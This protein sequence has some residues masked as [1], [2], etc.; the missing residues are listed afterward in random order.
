MPESCQ[1]GEAALARNEASDPQSIAAIRA[2][3]D[4]RGK[5]A[6]QRNFSEAVERTLIWEIGALGG[7]LR[8]DLP[9]AAAPAL[10]GRAR[11]DRGGDRHSDLERPLERALLR[12]ISRSKV[13]SSRR[14][15]GRGV[16]NSPLDHDR[17]VAGSD[18]RH[19]FISVRVLGRI[20][21][22]ERLKTSALRR[23]FHAVVER[24]NEAEITDRGWPPAS[25][26]AGEEDLDATGLAGGHDESR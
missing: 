6:N 14:K 13:Q 1:R 23:D 16:S 24:A 19:P 5:E 11:T 17:M 26:L 25:R 21:A 4:A 7:D 10:E 18:S 12:W 2:S 9:A 20:L 15:L 3:L 22:E 8:A